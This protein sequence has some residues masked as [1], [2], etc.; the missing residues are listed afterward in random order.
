MKKIILCVLL[1]VFMLV[2]CSEGE[3]SSSVIEKQDIEINSDYQMSAGAT[4]IC[5][6]DRSAII[7]VLNNQENLSAS[8]SLIINIPNQAVVM[9]FTVQHQL[10]LETTEQDYDEVRAAFD[11]V[12]SYY[13][14]EHKLD[15]TYLYYVGKGSFEEWNDDGVQTSFLHKV[16]DDTEKLKSN[17]GG[18]VYFEYDEGLDKEDKI[19][20]IEFNFGPDPELSGVGTFDR[21][22]FDRNNVQPIAVLPPDSSQVYMLADKETSVS[23]AVKFFEQKISGAPYPKNSNCEIKVSSVEVFKT[24]NNV[25]G[26]KMLCS[27][28]IGGVYTEYT[29][30]ETSFNTPRY[31]NMFPTFGYMLRSD[32][33]E[34]FQCCNSH[35]IIGDAKQ[36]ENIVSFEDAAAL[37]SSKLTNGVGFEV[38]R[39]ELLYCE[40]PIKDENGYNDIKTYSA[41]VLPVWKLSLYNPNDKNNYYCYLSADGEE[42]SYWSTPA[43]ATE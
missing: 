43:L 9:E 19:G 25:Y 42:F 22:S 29:H 30:E 31:E 32:E 41:H 34:M 36:Y 1:A 13:F 21:R 2:G 28:V 39:A 14:S 4:E 3:D 5:S 38:K 37:I 18:A 26:F 35:I 12:Y 15:E 27:R 24:G 33:I 7:E 20:Q 8:D 40:E 10:D 16:S 23:D 17:E 11:K 6:L